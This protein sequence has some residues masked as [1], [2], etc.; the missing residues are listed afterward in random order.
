MAYA[1][2]DTDRENLY[3]PFYD[4]DSRTCSEGATILTGSENP[5]KVWNFL[6]SKGLTP[7]QVAG[8]MGNI[9][10]ESAG[11][12]DPRVV[13]FAFSDP[14]HR[15]DTVPP[16]Q[17]SKGQP[18]YGLVQWTHPP[19]KQGLREL[20]AE[21]GVPPTEPLGVQLDYLWTELTSDDYKSSTL[22]PIKATE[23]YIEATDIFLEEYENPAH[24]ERT[25]PVRH[26]Q[27]LA[28]L[29]EFGSGTNAVEGVSN[30]SVSTCSGE[31]GG[32]P[33]ALDENGCPAE[34][35]EESQTVSAVGIRVHPCIAE[36]VE[37]V[38]NLANNE[39]LNMSGWGWRSV[40]R[41][42]ELRVKNGC[43]DVYSAPPGSCRIATA[44]PGRSNHERGSAVDFTCNGSTISSR[45]HPCFILLRDN[46]SLKNLP[47]EPWHWSINGG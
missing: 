8:I 9:E 2:T 38:V 29:Q 24:I 13:E 26:S 5:E 14:P 44:I 12:W 10:S 15:S 36:E 19:R 40:Q 25:R 16:D 27:A 31:S 23:D 6:I 33:V 18:G 30:V 20:Y 34:P 39:G 41:Q 22:E 35:V 28:W 21:R 42:E 47:S 46:T 45:S 1:L 37:R 43:P 7:A 17:N 3:T 4:P 11:T 32:G